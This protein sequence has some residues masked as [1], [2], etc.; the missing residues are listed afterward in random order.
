MSKKRKRNRTEKALQQP[1]R[2]EPDS[3][4]VARGFATKSASPETPLLH[5]KATK[6]ATGSINHRL[7]YVRCVT[8]VFGREVVVD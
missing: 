4:Q 2:G 3:E 1:V 5:Y 6:W 7:F 8:G